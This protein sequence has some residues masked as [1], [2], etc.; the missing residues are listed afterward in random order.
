MEI[1]LKFNLNAISIENLIEHQNCFR[2][3]GL[4]KPTLIAWAYSLWHFNQIFGRY[5]VNRDEIPEKLNKIFAFIRKF[6]LL[7]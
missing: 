3:D 7:E 2:N 5:T 1:R 6:Y 4:V